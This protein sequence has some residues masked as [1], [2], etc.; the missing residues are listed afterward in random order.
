MKGSA[1][2]IPKHD[3]L[4][5]ALEAASQGGSGLTFV[6][7]KERESFVSYREF[8]TRA[9][10]AAAF[11]VNLGIRPGDRIALIQSTSPEFVDSIFGSML[12]GAIPVPLY[13]P[14]RL[15]KLDDYHAATARM[16]SITGARLALLSSM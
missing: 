5:S 4:Q 12:A 7:I 3:T 1:A 16:L 8:H 13:P 11:F 6:D 14:L 15:G 2:L 9:R 10:R